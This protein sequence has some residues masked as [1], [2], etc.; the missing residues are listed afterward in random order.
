MIPNV[1]CV[2]PRYDFCDFP[3]GVRACAPIVPGCVVVLADYQKA[4]DMV[5][6]A[7]QALLEEPDPLTN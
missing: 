4:A 2:L 7:V 1:I 3:K 5:S 6:A